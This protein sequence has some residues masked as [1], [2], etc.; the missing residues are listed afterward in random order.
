M[1]G[2]DYSVT[3]P[4][5]AARLPDGSVKFFC[6]RQ[7]KK[8]MVKDDRLVMLDYPEY[9][10]PEQRYAALAKGLIEAVKGVVSLPCRVSIELYAFS[11]SGMITGL[12]EA[13]GVM[14]HYL[15]LDGCTISPYVASSIKK[16]ATGKGNATKRDMVNAFAKVVG[17]PYPWFD[18][19]DDGKE[20]IPSPISD[21]VDAYYVLTFGESQ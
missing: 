20:K 9:N 7:K 5:V 16:F 2:I 3:S 19:V 10:C 12:A 1:I 18:L 4:A 6:Y 8:H 13:T 15:W 11:A 14:K 21:I 17:D